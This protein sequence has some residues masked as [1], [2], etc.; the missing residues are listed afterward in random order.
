[1]LISQLKVSKSDI[2]VRNRNHSHLT[3]TGNHM[4]PGSGDFPAFTPAEVGTQFS[5]PGGMQG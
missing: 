5:D 4:S 3:A 2:A 1:M